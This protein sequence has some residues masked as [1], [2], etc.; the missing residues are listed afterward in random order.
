MIGLAYFAARPRRGVLM[1]L[2][3]LA[4]A[5]SCLGAVVFIVTEWLWPYEEPHP[6]RDL[7]LNA[8]GAALMLLT[9]VATMAA[10]TLVLARVAPV[11]GPLVDAPAALR[12]AAFVLATDACRY[13]THRLMHRPG[14]WRVHRFHHSVDV[15][16]WFSGMR[17]SPVHVVLFT[18]PIPLL[19]WLLQID[20]VVQALNLVA[21]ALSN[22]L[23][24]TNTRMPDRLQRILE[25]LIVTPRFHRFHHALD[26]AWRD[27]NF[28]A[29][30]TVWDR[31]FGTYLDPDRLR[32]VT[33][34]YGLD[35]PGPVRWPR[36]VMGL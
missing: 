21:M 17:A 9:G 3:L 4:F 7:V 22:H 20:P 19:A 6:L 13:A 5:A 10:L 12:I 16:N 15:L 34:R 1:N 26:P 33:L 30:F 25:W 32:G 11:G 27:W 23:M 24:H 28:G 2:D 31:W 8:A 29:M 18:A 36:T 35:E 14:W